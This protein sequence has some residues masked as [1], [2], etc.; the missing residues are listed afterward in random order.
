MIDRLREKFKNWQRSRL[1]NSIDN[2]NMAHI[3]NYFALF[4][5][6]INGKISGDDTALHLAAK[7]NMTILAEYLIKNGARPDLPSLDGNTALHLAAF[8]GNE[9]FCRLLIRAGANP[10]LKN[11]RK[12]SACDIFALQGMHALTYDS[13]KDKKD[14]GFA[15]HMAALA[16]HAELVKTLIDGGAGIH[17]LGHDGLTPLQNAVKGQIFKREQ[18]R[19][20]I[21]I[22][23]LERGAFPNTP[24][25][26]PLLLEAAHSG[27][28]AV[29]GALLAHGAN[30]AQRDEQGRTALHL[31]A[32]A[33]NNDAIVCL[34]E[35]YPAGI[36]VQDYAGNT[37]L[38]LAALR[39]CGTKTLEPLLRAGIDTGL[40]NAAGKTALDLLEKSTRNAPALFLL[41]KAECAPT[42]DEWTLTQDGVIWQRVNERKC[43]GLA[44]IFNFE[45]SARISIFKDLTAQATH[46]QPFDK[47]PFAD[48]EAAL[49]MR[50]RLKRNPGR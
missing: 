7:R 37:A 47:V 20:D 21:V 39:G 14:C 18:P 40:R 28:P 13:I 49:D 29:I 2:G 17:N 50:N 16:G 9:A 26:P 43:Y 22:L 24:E 27:S 42:S 46:T 34:L 10:S 8:Q 11:D 3:R 12:I 30:P 19:L 41:A 23:L 32:M 1:V 15:L 33:G 44:E 45:A 38:H 6:D 25:H 48:I 35:K 36:N 5:D 31:A 4:P